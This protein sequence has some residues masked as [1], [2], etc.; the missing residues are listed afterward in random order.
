MRRHFAP[1]ETGGVDNDHWVLNVAFGRAHDPAAVGL[2][3]GPRHRAE[4]FDGGRTMALR[5]PAA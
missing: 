4:P 3:F 2:L 1:P 5:A